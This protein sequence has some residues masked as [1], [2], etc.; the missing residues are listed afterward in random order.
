MHE[1]GFPEDQSGHYPGAI[2]PLAEHVNT[3]THCFHTQPAWSCAWDVGANIQLL[4]ERGLFHRRFE[5]DILAL[6]FDHIRKGSRELGERRFAC[7]GCRGGVIHWQRSALFFVL[8]GRV[9][10]RWDEKL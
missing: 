5:K 6:E 8:S 3:V 1:G 10:H 2:R 9:T 7:G 4:L